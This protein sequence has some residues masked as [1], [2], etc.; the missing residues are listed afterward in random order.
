MLAVAVADKERWLW[1]AEKAAE[2]GVT[3]LWPVACERS[4]HVASRLRDTH[5][6]RVTERVREA[7]KQS[8]TP[9]APVVHEIVPL[10]ELGRQLP[11][12]VLRLL[13]DAEGGPAGAA[14]RVTGPVAVLVG[15]EGG[16]APSER[17]ALLAD[18]WTPLRLAPNVLRF[19]TAALAAAALIQAHREAR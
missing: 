18:G 17:A 15:P 5:L 13:A 10:A 9:W 16:L 8:G 11:A 12:G 6:A 7:C 19:E 4:A 14:T 3:A 2:L 1:L